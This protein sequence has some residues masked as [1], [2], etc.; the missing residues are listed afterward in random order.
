MFVEKHPALTTEIP[1]KT[2][3]HNITTDLT[4]TDCEDWRFM[5]LAQGHAQWQRLVLAEP[6][7]SATTALHDLVNAMYIKVG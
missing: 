7:D 1:R 2:L 5:K 6:L 4:D 3:K